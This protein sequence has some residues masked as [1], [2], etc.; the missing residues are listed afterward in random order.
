MTG[1]GGGH[2]GAGRRPQ[3]GQVPE[4]RTPAGGLEGMPGSGLGLSSL[5]F[6]LYHVPGDRPRRLF[7]QASSSSDVLGFYQRKIS[8]LSSWDVPGS[9]SGP[10]KSPVHRWSQVPFEKA[11]NM[12]PRSV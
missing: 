12:S 9:L 10:S 2:G 1:R 11:L 6:K 4:D 8:C 7:A 3:R 5:G